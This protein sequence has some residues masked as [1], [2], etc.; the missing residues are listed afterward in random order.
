MARP[1]PL[2]AGVTPGQE[3][4]DMRSGK[5]QWVAST[6]LRVVQAAVLT[7]TPQQD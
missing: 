3:S 2:R 1:L 7:P 5:H 6:L 4:N